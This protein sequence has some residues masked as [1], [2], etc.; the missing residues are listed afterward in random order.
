M[1]WLKIDY[2]KKH[3]R[4]DY[5]CEDALLEL[6]GEAA[7]DTVMNIIGRDYDD[8]VENFG[9]DKHPVP[10]AI[11]QASLILVDTSFMQRTAVSAQNLYAVPY[12][13][14]FLIKPFMKLTVDEEPEPEPEPDP[15]EPE[16]PEEVVD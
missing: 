3:S 5:D 12:A 9:T 6:Y 16:F 14:D 13:F 11:I 8:I 4:I 15:E 7:E 10:A 2:I 1:K